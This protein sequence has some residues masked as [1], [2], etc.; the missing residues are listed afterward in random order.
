MGS[1]DFMEESEKLWFVDLFLFFFFFP[2]DVLK[3]GETFG[4]KHLGSKGVHVLGWAEDPGEKQSVDVQG[5]GFFLLEGALGGSV[6]QAANIPSPTDPLGMDLWKILVISDVVQPLKF[7]GIVQK[8]FDTPNVVYDLCSPW[9]GCRDILDAQISLILGH[10][11][12]QGPVPYGKTIPEKPKQA[13]NSKKKKNA[14][15]K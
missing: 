6:P 10:S 2:G 8:G 4:I 5:L 1:S 14:L 11:K 9:K 3:E 15:S 12:P 13:I 7:L